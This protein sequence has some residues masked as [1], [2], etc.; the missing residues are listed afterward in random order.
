MKYTELNGTSYHTETPP[1]MREL[2]ERLRVNRTRCRFHWGDTKTGRDWGDDHWVYGHIGRSMGPCKI[3]LL[4]HNA[5]SMG[6]GGIL[7][8]CIV[9]IRYANK[10][11]GGDIYRHPKYH[12]E[13]EQC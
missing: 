6:G 4:V 7:D 11:D 5:R 2:L 12:E 9:R 3:P 13:A 8:H 1:D 10:A